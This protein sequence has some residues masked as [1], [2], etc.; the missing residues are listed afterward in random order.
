M[1]RRALSLAGTAA[2]KAEVPVGAVVYG[3]DGTI[4]GEGGNAPVSHRDVSAHAEIL[5]L[6]QACLRADNYRL[7]HLHMVVTLEPCP[8]C[9]GAIMQARLAT[10]TYATADP[11][12]GACGSVANLPA[13]SRLNHHTVFRGG[14]FADES[15]ALLQQFFRDRR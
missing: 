7:P 11:K 14:L 12:T 13:D 3:E 9:V 8:M 1:M 5:A 4:W 10:L 6:R 2:A 15:A